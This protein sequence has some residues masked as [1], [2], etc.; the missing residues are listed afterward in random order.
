VLWAFR[1]SVYDSAVSEHV[2]L[3]NAS[4]E[5][6]CV[7]SWKRAVVLV[8]SGKA[9]TIEES[10]RVV[11]SESFNMVVPSVARL[12]RFVKVPYERKA[13]LNLK[14]VMQRDKYE[15]CYCGQR[16]STVDHVLPRSRG[17]IHCWINV[18]A[19]CLKCNRIKGDRTPEE[20]GWRMRFKPFEPNGTHRFTVTCNFLD[21]TWEQWIIAA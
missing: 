10:N 21:P 19:C 3:L 13:R 14:S 9:E 12:V 2:L 5:P 16:A 15:C 20:M 4:F 7:V 17:G 1:V 18:V 11:R 8:L 6:L